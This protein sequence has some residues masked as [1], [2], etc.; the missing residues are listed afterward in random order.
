ME[1]LAQLLKQR[2]A[3]G[4]RR[5]S[6]TT[7]GKWAQE[8]RIMGPPCPGRWSYEH[9]PWAEEPQECIAEQMVAQ[10]AAQ[11]A[12]TEI[13]LNKTFKA[14]DIDAYNVLYILPSLHPDARDFSTSRFDA[15]LE[16]SPHLASLFTDVKNIGHKRAGSA[17]LFIRGSRSRSQ[18]KSI[19]AN[20]IVFDEVD[21]MV[22]EN[23]T[24]AMERMSGQ[25]QRQVYMISTPTI[26]NFGINVYF[27][28]GD[29]RHY[30]FKCPHCSRLT[31]LVFPDC[32]HICGDSFEDPAIKESY[33]FCKEC[34]HKL[35]HAAK[36]T[37]LAKG[38]AEW[39]PTV[40]GTEIV[41][42]YINQL[43]SI[44]L[45]PY[46]IAEL[47]FKAEQ[48]PT[49][50]QELYN[51]KGGLPHVVKGG[52]VTDEQITACIGHNC[53][54]RPSSNSFVTMGVDVG[55]V[56]HV[57]IDE[58]NFNHR[59]FEADL[60]A[61]ASCR[62]LK[63]L[64]VPNFHDL[65]ELM[66]EFRVGYCVIDIEPETRSSLEFAKRFLHSVRM[67]KY[68]QGV[69]GKLIKDNPE[70][71]SVQVNRTSW[72]DLS[73]GRFKKRTITLPTDVDVEYREHIC[74][75]TRIYDKDR[76]GN[77]VGRYESGKNPDHY[78][79]ARNY[80]EIALALGV[81]LGGNR[82]FRG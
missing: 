48:D 19:P 51:S 31:E 53:D 30:M 59:V 35:D 77:P 75:P 81:Q 34:K 65:D 10:K 46:K 28:Q 58:W 18:L 8:Y 17:N 64:R 29:Q 52:K 26:E 13:A 20:L 36:K 72:L 6:I 55:K 12:F 2:V 3:S 24:L 37:F 66:L 39:V 11:M 23:I 71:L 61:L 42:Y 40:Q 82:D 67:C 63:F 49:D 69:S 38:N 25:L 80:A 76:D 54:V 56:L 32:L 5:K 45:P 22:F 73:L 50:E 70:E 68:A 15:A 43:Y 27:K 7:A 60:N 21:E 33:I 16:L 4:L 14:I 74:A 78:A 1:D 44:I 9:H 47:C 62:V 79:H 57:E 41:S